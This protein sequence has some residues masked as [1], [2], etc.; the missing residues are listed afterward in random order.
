MEALLADY[1]AVRE[2]RAR[3]WEAAG[4]TYPSATPRAIDRHP[5][6]LPLPPLAP[7]V[8]KVMGRRVSPTPH[9]QQPPR[10]RRRG[11]GGPRF[12][13]TVALELLEGSDEEP[14]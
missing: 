1:P 12:V 9:S 2:A 7:I 11:A 14:E 4:K 8:A 5:A 10:P 3:A 13:L 6:P